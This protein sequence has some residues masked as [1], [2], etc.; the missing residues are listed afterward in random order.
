[1]LARRSRDTLFVARA[2][3]HK[4]T[5]SCSHATAQLYNPMLANHSTA[6][7]RHD[8]RAPQHSLMLE[9]RN[10]DTQYDAPATQNSSYTAYTY[11]CPLTHH[12]SDT[13]S[14]TLAHPRP[15]TLYTGALLPSL[16]VR[17]HTVPLQRPDARAP[18]HI[19]PLLQP[20]NP[21]LAHRN[22]A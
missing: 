6:I 21:M 16:S 14:A 12:C 20:H 3:Q 13:L 10:T 18:Q 22:T 15:A 8:A 1:M 17:L 4:Y 5:A 9:Y 19:Q 7:T 2:P 11:F